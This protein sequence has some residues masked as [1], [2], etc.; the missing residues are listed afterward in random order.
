MALGSKIASS[1]VNT[2][3]FTA[4]RNAE[5]WLAT[6]TRVAPKAQGKTIVQN[7]WAAS[8]TSSANGVINNTK[9]HGTQP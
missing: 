8:S 1:L 4:P 2:T 3:R 9:F 6:S 5:Q 7:A